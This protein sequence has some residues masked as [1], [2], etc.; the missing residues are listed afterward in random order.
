MKLSFKKTDKEQHNF[1]NISLFITAIA[2]VLTI[3]YIVHG[4]V[5]DPSTTTMNY[6]NIVQ[7]NVIGFRLKLA[8]GLIALGTIVSYVITNTIA[9][10]TLGRWLFQPDSVADDSNSKAAK[11]LALGIVFGGSL[12]GIFGIIA[13]I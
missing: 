5:A 2:L 8:A 11:I 10:S 4:V 9:H 12:V 1:I 6:E 7:A 3:W 13:N